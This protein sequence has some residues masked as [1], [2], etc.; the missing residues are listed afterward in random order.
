MGLSTG[1]PTASVGPEWGMIEPKWGT[2][3][4]GGGSQVSPIRTN[5][6]LRALEIRLDLYEKLEDEKAT[7]LCSW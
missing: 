7:V 5:S 1:T 2:G 4:P 6:A 3:T